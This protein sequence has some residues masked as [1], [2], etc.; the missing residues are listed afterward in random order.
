MSLGLPVV[1]TIKC[2]DNIGA[3]NVYIISVKGIKAG[4]LNRLP[5]AC[6]GGM[7]MATVKKGPNNLEEICLVFDV[8]IILKL[9]NIVFNNVL[10]LDHNGLLQLWEFKWIALIGI[11]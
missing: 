8:L 9:L 11:F 6:V 7:V 3:K 10:G 1:A 5:S 4:R 2:A